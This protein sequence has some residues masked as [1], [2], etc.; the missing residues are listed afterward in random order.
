MSVYYK[1]GKIFSQTEGVNGVIL[2]HTNVSERRMKSLGDA[3]SGKSKRVC[4]TN[5][6]CRAP[7]PD[8][9]TQ[10]SNPTNIP[11]NLRK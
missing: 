10:G 2:R 6:T 5:E 8:T 9:I 4:K 3:V 1:N 11:S 7:K